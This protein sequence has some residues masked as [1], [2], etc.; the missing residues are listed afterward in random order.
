MRTI[1]RTLTVAFGLL[2][3]GG[4]AWLGVTRLRPT[5][6]SEQPLPIKGSFA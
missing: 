3:L 2:Q 6:R 1:G 5:E 4:F